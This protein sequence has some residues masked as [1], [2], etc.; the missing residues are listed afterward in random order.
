MTTGLYLGPDLDDG[1]YAD[2]VVENGIYI[3]ETAGREGT[4]N[5]AGTGNTNRTFLVMG[6]ADPLTCRTALLS[7]AAETAFSVRT[8]DGLF[9]E[10]M[11]RERIGPESWSFT[12][13]YSPFTPEVGGYTISVDTTGG[14]LLRTV[15]ISETRYGSGAPNFG[16]AIDVQDGVAQGVETGIPAMKV[17]VRA[18]ISSTYIPS[19][20]QY[21]NLAASLTFTT[22]SVAEFG[23]HYAA[24][25]LLFLGMTGEIIGPDPMLTFS[26]LAS[27][28]LTSQTIAGISGIAKKGH[29]YLWCY[30][31]SAVES[32]LVVRRPKGIYVNDVYRSANWSAL[33]I[34][35]APET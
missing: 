24:G 31:E 23:G 4:D 6:S 33:K 8:Y 9:L 35:I 1:A 16:G 22:N 26:F 29:Q 5:V 3:R 7:A 21:S 13:N 17:N 34:G 14:S 25:E 20:E 12:V 15:A 19:P 30:F 10:S 32:G 27:P 18:R 11:S 2:I 28:N